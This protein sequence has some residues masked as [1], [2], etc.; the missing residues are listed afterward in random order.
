MYL[1]QLR[2]QEQT[3]I[4]VIA[5]EGVSFLPSRER[6]TSC[7]YAH[8]Q[9]IASQKAFFIHPSEFRTAVCVHF[10]CR[11]FECEEYGKV[12]SNCIEGCVKFT[13]FARTS[14]IAQDDII[15]GLSCI[16]F[17]VVLRS[18]YSKI[19]R[20][21]SRSKRVLAYLE[22][23]FSA[24]LSG[25]TSSSVSREKFFQRLPPFYAAGLGKR[26]SVFLRAIHDV[27]G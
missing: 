8:D 22:R 11:T 27:C 10:S 9:N 18:R 20:D 2:R 3:L 13:H 12:D 26:L 21:Y 6:H 4:V 24:R 15:I 5:F 19:G 23:T 17:L 25:R 7:H 14:R 16:G 1:V